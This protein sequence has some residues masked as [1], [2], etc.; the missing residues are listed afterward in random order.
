[1]MSRSTL[2]ALIISTAFFMQGLDSTIV[3]S[4]LPQ[5]AFAFHEDPVRLSGAITSYVL[6]LAVFIPISGW[7]ADR[8]GARSALQAAI[9]IFTAGSLLCGLSQNILEL[10]LA[11]VLQGMGGA[12]LVPV[13]RLVILKTVGKS[14]LVQAMAILSVP[15]QLGPLL[16]P[17]IGGMIVTYLSW[18]WVF[19]VNLPVGAL[20]LILSSIF[21]ENFKEEERR[22]LDWI[23]FLLGGAALCS[24]MYAIEMLGRAE[25]TAG[26]PFLAAGVALGVL[27]VRHARQHPYPMIDVSLVRLPSFAANFYG[28]TLFRL[29]LGS[30][31]F[32]LPILFQVVFG[33]SAFVSGLLVF[34]GAI[35]SMLM[36]TATPRILRRFGYRAVITINGVITALAL[37]ACGFF[38][39][40]TPLPVIFVVLLVGGFLQSL[41]FSTLNSLPYAEVPSQKMSSATSLTQLMQ[42]IGRGSGVA[43]AAGVLHMTLALRGGS[44]L[45]TFEFL[46][47]FTISTCISLASVIFFYRLPRNAG[48]E[49]SGHLSQAIAN[50]P[51]SASSRMANKV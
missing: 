51:D 44:E 14:G 48:A 47:A 11:R 19:L 27:M 29:G 35:G 2:I 16:G 20:G 25:L 23:G 1:M 4:A 28:G 30:Q 46:V 39:P 42:Q 8:F 40:S 24:T 18:Q 22:P 15:A 21:V 41:Q 49:L 26:A 38:T 9:V 13:G 5:I 36:K 17:P 34:A 12:M 45:T 33:M 3:A 50:A 7:I 10:S 31:A 6:S 32:L 43:M 37:L